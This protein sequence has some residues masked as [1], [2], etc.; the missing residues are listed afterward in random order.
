MTEIPEHLRNRTKGRRQAL[1]LPVTDGDAAPGA[2]TP[3]VA[4]GGAVAPAG[5][6]ALAPK[7]PVAPTG[8]IE[9]AKAA[10][11]P[12]APYV[13]AFNRRKRIPVWAMPAVFGLPLW[14]VIYAGTLSPP[15][16]NSL[17]LIKEG[18]VVFQ[19]CAA[20]HGG[21]GGGGVGPQLS[22]GKVLQTFSNPIDQVRWVISGSTGHVGSTY[23]DTKK[24]KKGGMPAFGGQLSLTEIVAVVRHE[25]ESLTG[26]QKFAEEATAW[27]ELEKVPAEFPKVFKDQ[28]AAA[29]EVETILEELTVQT[30]AVVKPEGEKKA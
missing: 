25:R 13:A 8:S 15:P 1:G 3:A 2:A 4:S 18:E 23:G 28:K 30:G 6:G 10:P 19:S 26:G 17:T 11:K 7:G 9:A 16:P 24:P 5:G 20:C 22:E 29:L 12:I 27:A 14:G 21:T